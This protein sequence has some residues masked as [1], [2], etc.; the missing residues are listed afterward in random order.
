MIGTISRTKGR[1]RRR[2]ERVQKV[3][4]RKVGKVRVQIKIGVGVKIVE[5][6]IVGVKIVGVI[7]IEFVM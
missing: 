6:K 2:R 1:R 5:V 4:A 7:G 3:G